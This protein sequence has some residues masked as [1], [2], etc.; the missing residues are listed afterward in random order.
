MFYRLKWNDHKKLRYHRPSL[1]VAMLRYIMQMNNYFQRRELLNA[2]RK[3]VIF[4]LPTT[5]SLIVDN[6]YRRAK[7]YADSHH[8]KVPPATTTHPPAIAF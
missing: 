3:N 7:P 4:K 6:I 1:T 2:D 8:P 5:G